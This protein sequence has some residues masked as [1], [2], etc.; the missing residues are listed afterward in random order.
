M[1]YMSMKDDWREFWPLY[2]VFWGGLFVAFA[3]F[4]YFASQT[5]GMTVVKA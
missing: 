1:V 3:V 2:C 5:A 4:V